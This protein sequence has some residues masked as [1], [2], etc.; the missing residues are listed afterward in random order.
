[1]PSVSA[2]QSAIKLTETLAHLAR[3]VQADLLWRRKGM[4]AATDLSPKWS[5]I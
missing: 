5:R 3:G 1:M 2:G 4:K